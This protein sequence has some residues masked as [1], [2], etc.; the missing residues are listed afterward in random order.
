MKIG[1]IYY[2]FYPVSGGASVHGYN[3]ARELHRLGYELYKI[4]GAADPYTNKIENP[5]K[6]IF[7]ILKN[8]DVIYLRMDYFLNLRNLVSIFSH[9]GGKKL[10]VE[11]NTPSDELHLFGRGRTYIRLADRVMS[12]IL[13]H[14]DMVI[15]VSKP[16][17]KYCSEALGVEN[18]TVVENGGEIFSESKLESSESVQLKID[19]I[20]ERYSKIV[21]WSG[22]LNQ[23]QDL[24]DIQKIADRIKADTAVILI[25][26]EEA[27]SKDIL[28][29]SE[30][31]YIFKDISRADVKYIITNS[32]IGLAL[33]HDYDWSR[34][35]FYNSS[36]KIFEYLNNGL[37]TITNTKGTKIQRSYPNF[38]SVNDLN[39]LIETIENDYKTAFKIESPRTWREVAQETSEIIQNIV[40]R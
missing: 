23:M 37:L 16:L 33:Y 3:L 18:V 30:N 34:W 35:G 27:N 40:N 14:A 20:R 38:R 15:T 39:Q 21:V 32:D 26:K 6:G 7:W 25:V 12:L 29:T 4:N 31:L 8:C 13:N 17:K 9:L 28:Q 10:I 11:L 1:F 36:L 5:V 19:Q 24:S 22:S 2:T